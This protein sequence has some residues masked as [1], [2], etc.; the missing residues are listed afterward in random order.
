MIDVSTMTDE[1][2]MAYLLTQ[3][4]NLK[5][6]YSLVAPRVSAFPRVTVADLKISDKEGNL[7]PLVWNQEQ[8]AW[9][10]EHDLDLNDPDLRTLRMRDII[11]KPR[12]R[13]FSTMFAA[14]LFL[15]ICNN[16]R[17]RNVTIAHDKETSQ[18]IFEKAHTFYENLP[19]EKKRPKKYSNKNELHFMD[20]DSRY[21][22]G[23]AGTD[24]FGS[25]TTLHNVH[26]TE[27]A[28]WSFADPQKLA[29]LN[30]SMDAAALQGNI[31]VEST[32]NGVNHFEQEYKDARDKR[33]A[34]RSRFFAWFENDEYGRNCPEDYKFEGADEAKRLQFKL[35]RDQMYWYVQTRLE[36]K[37]LMTQEYPFT[38][39]EAFIASAMVY[40]DR[41]KLLELWNH[42]RS[43]EYDPRTDIVIHPGK[44]PLLAREYKAGT[45]QIWEPPKAG[46]AYIIPAD[47][48]RGEDAKSDFDSAG[49]WDTI[50]HEQCCHLHGRWD[51]ET[52]GE[53]LKELYYWYNQALLAPERTGLGWNLI[54][55]LRRIGIPPQ[56][57]RACSGLY[58][59]D[60][61][62][63]TGTKRPAADTIKPGWDTNQMTKPYACGELNAAL[64]GGY[65]GIMSR[66]L[67]AEMLTFMRLANGEL[68]AAPGKYD[69]RVAEAFIAAALLSLKFHKLADHD[70]PEPRPPQ[71]P[72]G[73]RHGW[74][75]EEREEQGYE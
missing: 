65:I 35:T 62:L 42:L 20:N 45:F 15:N 41:E 22:I 46:R 66:D 1:E 53:L 47:V 3:G 9:L 31:W 52:Y 64:V 26:K 6:A 71:M 72:Y 63:I 50:S 21:F 27:Y 7:I 49:A 17:M 56:R 51:I 8:E 12:Q 68:G 69:D 67:V 29:D 30:A 11:L 13:G 59:H 70:V 43:P 39:E 34:Y 58:H 75:E 10:R 24:Y 74:R 14:L 5:A 28:K 25:G 38:D 55:T 4:D 61:T 23:T 44:F 19:P 37:G 73:V 57:G 16:S 36:F 60:A 33:S 32:A 2:A 54:T 18:A 40:F 48:S